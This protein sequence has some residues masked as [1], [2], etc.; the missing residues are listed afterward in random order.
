MEP[1]G[2]LLRLQVPTTCPYPG[3][4]QSTSCPHIPFPK[5][6]SYYYPPIYALVFQM[7]MFPQVS[8]PKPF[9][10]LHSPSYVLHVKPI[11]FFLI[12]SPK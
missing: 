5:D 11:S 1:E 10:H 6:P 2:S 9:I 7:A 12:W 3:P 4:D 8:P